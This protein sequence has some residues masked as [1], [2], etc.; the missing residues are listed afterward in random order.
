MQFGPRRCEIE[1]PRTNPSF[2]IPVPPS[3][4][5]APLASWDAAEWEVQHFEYTRPDPPPLL[6]LPTGHPTAL[7]LCARRRFTLIRNNGVDGSALEIAAASQSGNPSTAAAA[8]EDSAAVP[9]Y[10]GRGSACEVAGLSPNTLYHFRVRA[11]NARTRSPL[12][13]PLEASNGNRT[14]IQDTNGRF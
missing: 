2:K 9:C 7:L 3:G 8:P 4:P 14:R 5:L 13:S 11:V 1:G 6:P 12:S 10:K